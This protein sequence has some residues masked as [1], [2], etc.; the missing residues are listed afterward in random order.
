ML[1]SVALLPTS[2]WLQHKRRAG[3]G[4]LEL[5]HSSHLTLHSFFNASPMK[6]LLFDIDGTLL[7]VQRGVNRAVVHGVARRLLEHHGELPELELHGKTDP[8]IF[9][10]IAEHLRLERHDAESRLRPLELVITEEW[11]QHLSQETVEILPGVVDLLERL[12][13]L[14]NVHLGLLTGNVA[15]GASAKLRPH[16]LGKYFTVG[17]YG[18]DSAV[19]NHLPPIAIRRAAELHGYPFQP[20]QTLIIGDSHRD[21][22]CARLSG[23]RSLAVATGGL[24]VDQLRAHNPDYLAETLLDDSPIHAFISQ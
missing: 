3:F 23:V 24:S 14:P 2:T 12:T 20:S 9:L 17:A 1:D 16:G 7:R 18:S 4:G 22:E 10:E 11:E 8:Q 21:I 13:Q 5:F 15:S 6:L 19:R